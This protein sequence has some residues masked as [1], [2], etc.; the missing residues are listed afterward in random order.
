MP[1]QTVVRNQIAH[2]RMQHALADEV[3]NGRSL[4][5]SARETDIRSA[6]KR[7]VPGLI[8]TQQRAHLPVQARIGERIRGELIAEEVSNYLICE[9]DRVEHGLPATPRSGGVLGVAEEISGNRFA[10][11]IDRGIAWTVIGH[12]QWRFLLRGGRRHD[13][14]E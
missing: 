3:G 13:L 2:V 5:E 9:G 14:R 1:I 6:K 8:E 7:S 12:I 4:P 10:E 11:E